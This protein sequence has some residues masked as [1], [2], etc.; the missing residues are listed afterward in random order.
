MGAAPNV[1]RMSGTFESSL[2]GGVAERADAPDT[3]G[4]IVEARTPTVAGSSPA[5]AAQFCPQRPAV[6]LVRGTPSP[7]C[8][9]T[10]GRRGVPKKGVDK[11]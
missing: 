1:M 2:R 8:E 7:S 11:Q 10:P 5:V 6:R 9:P 4:G 3:G